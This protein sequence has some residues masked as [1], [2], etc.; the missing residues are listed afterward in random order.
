MFNNYF[1]FSDFMWMEIM[2]RKCKLWWPTFLSISKKRTITPKKP[3][4]LYKCFCNNLH[5]VHLKSKVKK[6]E[7]F[8]ISKTKVASQGSVNL[9]WSHLCLS[10]EVLTFDMQD[11]FEDTKEVIRIHKSKTD[12][13]QNGQKTKDKNKDLQKIVT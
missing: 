7:I 8:E 10:E 13:Q 3:S 2:K 5:W 6:K 12:G 1:L 9:G 11:E 4:T